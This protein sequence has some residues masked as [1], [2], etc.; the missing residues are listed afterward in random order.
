MVKNFLIDEEGPVFQMTHSPHPGDCSAGEPQ[1]PLPLE[2]LAHIRRTGYVQWTRKA[3][4][5]T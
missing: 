5:A 1:S 4:Q 2:G 3:L